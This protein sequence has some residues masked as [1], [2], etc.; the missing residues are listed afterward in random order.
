MLFDAHCHLQMP[1]LKPV[2]AE[3]LAKYAGDGWKAAVNGT[4]PADW[5][6]VAELAGTHEVV[7]PQF[8]LHPWEVTAV[9]P[10]WEASLRDWLTRFPHAGVGEIGLDKWIRDA[11]L[12]A[13]KAGFAPQWELA[14][15]LSRPITVH[16]LKAFGNLLDVV[17]ALPQAPR[18]FLLHAYG[19]PPDLLRQFLDAGAYFSFNLYFMADRKADQ[20]EVFRQIP[21]DRLLIETDAPAMPPPN[22]W[23]DYPQTDERGQPLNDPRNLEATLRALAEIRGE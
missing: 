16:C 13:Q 7:R 19:G 20:R 11:D 10:G 23:R 18:G 9:E 12:P 22:G 1:S 21:R 4:Q 3:V 5:A 15:E 17:G 14:C 2:R 8:G 6:T